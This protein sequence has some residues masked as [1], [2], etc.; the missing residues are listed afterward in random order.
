[1]MTWPQSSFGL[2]KVD[3]W[4]S[5][6]WCYL[7]R[8]LRTYTTHC[9]S[10]D[11]KDLTTIGR[12]WH[13]F[14]GRGPASRSV[15][16]IYNNQGSPMCTHIN[17]PA[18]YNRGTHRCMRPAANVTRCFLISAHS[19]V[20]D[21]PV[22]RRSSGFLCCWTG[23]GHDGHKGPGRVL[24]HRLMASSSDPF[25]FSSIAGQY[26]NGRPLPLL[27]HLYAYSPVNMYE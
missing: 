25:S 1:M 14:N 13:I 15:G 23:H 26:N 2:L 22:W 11:E 8:W 7:L 21:G 27:S 4:F 12:R 10:D 20:A 19:D 9:V 18:G 5:S 3:L 6:L 24:C 17:R 16:P